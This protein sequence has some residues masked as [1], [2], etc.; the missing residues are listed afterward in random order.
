MMRNVV[1]FLGE[2]RKAQG[3][4]ERPESQLMASPYL[5]CNELCAVGDSSCLREIL[6]Y[7]RQWGEMDNRRPEGG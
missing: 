6:T 1:A 2:P 3:Q 4:E 7:N 5:L